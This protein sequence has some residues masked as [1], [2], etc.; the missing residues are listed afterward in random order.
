MLDLVRPERH[1]GASDR[2]IELI[3]DADANGAARALSSAQQGSTM[4]V[5]L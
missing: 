3:Q 4:F 5:R 1:P 2:L